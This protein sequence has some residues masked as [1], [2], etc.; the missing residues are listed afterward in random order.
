M[1]FDL[2][3]I[4]AGLPVAASLPELSHALGNQTASRTTAVIQAPPGT[5][6]TTLIPPALHNYTKGKIL[7]TAPRRVAVRAA[8]RRL[9]H[10]D[11]QR[12]RSVGFAVRGEYQRGDAVE[13]VTPG[14]LLRRLLTDPGLEGISG[15]IIDEVHERQLDT[16]LTLGMLRELH[17]LRNS[18]DSPFYL[19]AMSATVDAQRYSELLDNAPIIATPAVTH[20][21]EV[22]YRPG[23]QRL[24]VRGV[25]KEYLEHVARVAREGVEKH[26]ES[27]L[28]FVPGVREVTAACELLDN[29]IPLHGGLSAQEQ[30]AALTDRGIPRIIVSTS[31]AES[32]VTV[33]G[34]RVVVDSGLARQPQHDAARGISGLVTVGCARSSAEQRAG[35]AGRE[36]PGTVY[37]CYTE[38]EFAHMTPHATPEIFTTDL[39]QAALFMACWG[40]PDLPLID[41]P[42]PGPF[43]QAQATLQQLGAVD[44]SGTVTNFGR[45]LASIPCDPRLGRALL[46]TGTRRAAGIVA[47]LADDPRG[48]IARLTPNKAEAQRLHSLVTSS[49]SHDDSPGVV[50]GLAYPEFIA[51]RV[52][53][54]EFLLASG[55][56]AVTRD[57]TFAGTE[58]LAVASLSSAGERVYIHAAA[59]LS[60][61]EALS[62]IGVSETVEASL[63]NGR[64][65]GRK[66]RRAGKIELSSTPVAVPPEQAAEA[67]VA[68]L[69]VS[70]FTW[71]QAATELRNRLAFVRAQRGEPWPDVSDAAL[72]SMLGDWLAPEI[73]DIA[74][75]T[76][77]SQVDMLPALRRL[78]PWP[79]AASFDEYAPPQ[80]AV[81][82]GRHVFVE[83]STGRPVVSVKLQECFG[84]AESPTLCGQRV[85]FHLL[86]PAGRPLAVTDDLASFWSGPYSQVRAD[87]R[88][89][90]PKH[91]W[92]ED[93][94]SAEATG[95]VKGRGKR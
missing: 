42:P 17:E 22:L 15:V 1:A 40:S 69:D 89:R 87:M 9:R 58:W 90:Y 13:F 66:V 36:G 74:Q 16:D 14:V 65:R 35:R 20:P 27:V 2:D 76:P 61:D 85:L 57:N 94:W 56:R 43:Q 28:V 24:G 95:R 34:V 50:T 26:G 4:G 72:N 7:V 60:E 79:E 47:C 70:L 45:R 83:Y 3:R 37:R 78:V 39:T 88:G 77:L 82:S 51:K 54:N 86:S 67:L 25:E 5:G 8:A 46:L 49:G 30:D 53:E 32:S 63:V 31:I 33:P 62:L 59:H 48:D 71:S 93:P 6:K 12:A 38:S 91:P 92:P 64:I 21:V 23:P 11:P 52:G 68:G 73:Q 29:A 10:L 44:S 81:P 80:L 84:L 41:A 75:G 55:T 19:V 18:L